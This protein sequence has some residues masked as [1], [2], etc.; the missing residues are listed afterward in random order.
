MHAGGM[1]GNILVDCSVDYI[2][3]SKRSYESFCAGIQIWILVS[4][5]P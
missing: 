2:T 4:D 3:I 5:I 1:T